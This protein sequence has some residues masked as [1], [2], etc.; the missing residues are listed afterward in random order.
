M[1]KIKKNKEALVNIDF[2]GDTKPLEEFEHCEFISCRFGDLS[3]LNFRDCTFKNCNLSNLQTMQSI[4]QNCEF[5]ACKVLGIN[6]SQAKDFA[7]E[8]QFENCDL[9]SASFD[10]KKL[11]KS[12][13]KNSKLHGVNFT[14]ADLSKC[15]FLNCDFYEALFAG[16]D[17][18]G[19]DLSACINFIIDPELNKIKRARFSLQSLPGLLQRYEISVEDVSA[20]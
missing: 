13:F 6:F 5:N 12:S 16:T 10:K 7:F 4:F 1:S 15:T 17:L 14:Q 11:N 20:P 19:T 2:S 9:D 3:H 8:V 18:S